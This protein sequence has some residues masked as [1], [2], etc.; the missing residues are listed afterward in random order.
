MKVEIEKLKLMSMR[1]EIKYLRRFKK[2]IK[3]HY[4]QEHDETLNRIDQSKTQTSP[5]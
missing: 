2:S 4:P 5:S 3:A 1:G